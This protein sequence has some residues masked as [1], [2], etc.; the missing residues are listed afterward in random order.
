M[1][2]IVCSFIYLEDGRALDTNGRVLLLGQVHL[3]L[4]TKI[5]NTLVLNFTNVATV[6]VADVRACS[7]V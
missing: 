2:H 6:F 7:C 4:L 5:S 1:N 3:D